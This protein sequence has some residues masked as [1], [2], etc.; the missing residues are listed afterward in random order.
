MSHS[1][2]D[3]A[4]LAQLELAGSNRV[5]YPGYQAPSR[6]ELT[7]LNTNLNDMLASVSRLTAPKEELTAPKEE[8]IDPNTRGDH[9]NHMSQH[10]PVDTPDVDGARRYK[11]S[12]QVEH[13]GRSK[14]KKT[15]SCRWCVEE[16][17]ELEKV[18]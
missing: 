12:E 18:T 17:L 15:K 13:Q 5:T 11:G 1:R 9:T 7:R 6:S 14:T 16:Q 10:G 8:L 4:Y 3:R 2:K